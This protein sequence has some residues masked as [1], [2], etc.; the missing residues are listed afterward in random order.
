MASVKKVLKE[1]SRI[2]EVEK[3]FASKKEREVIE[4]PFKAEQTIKIDID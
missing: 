3:E 1:V 2:R 4:K